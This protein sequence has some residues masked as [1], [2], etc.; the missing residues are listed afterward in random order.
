M[1]SNSF[2]L[3]L[4]DHNISTHKKETRIIKCWFAFVSYNVLLI[5]TFLISVF[6]LSN[7]RFSLFRAIYLKTDAVLLQYF[8]YS[9]VASFISLQTTPS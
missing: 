1:K 6:A 9:F 2:C 4:F 8:H 5:Y 3:L 7:F